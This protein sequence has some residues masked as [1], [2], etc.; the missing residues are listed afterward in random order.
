MNNNDVIFIFELFFIA[1]G[2]K[3]EILRFNK[4]SD[5]NNNKRKN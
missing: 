3:A 2:K 4:N 5:K 1:I